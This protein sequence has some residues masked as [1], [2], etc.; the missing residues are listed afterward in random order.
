LRGERA[1][2]ALC[3]EPTEPA[4]ETAARQSRAGGSFCRKDDKSRKK[5]GF[6]TAKW[7]FCKLPSGSW[8]VSCTKCNLT[9]SHIPRKGPLTP[10]LPQKG[11]Q[12][13]SVSS[14]FEMRCI[15]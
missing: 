14:P 6:A 9:R 13:G 5:R 1:P 7:E 8:R 15:E 3:R 2:V 11:F 12:R 10:G 4:G